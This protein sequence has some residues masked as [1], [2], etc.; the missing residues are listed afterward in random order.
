MLQLVT[1]E[2][3]LAH[4]ESGRSRRERPSLCLSW[5]LDPSTGKPVARWIVAGAEPATLPLSSAA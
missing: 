3:F 5:T 2:A 4:D 1:R